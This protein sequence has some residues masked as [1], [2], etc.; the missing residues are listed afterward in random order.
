MANDVQ[1]LGSYLRNNFTK[2]DWIAVAGAIALLLGGIWFV[3]DRTIVAET[4]QIRADIRILEDEVEDTKRDLT[5]Q[6][7]DL[8]TEFGEAE[9]RIVKAFDAFSTDVAASVEGGLTERTDELSRA[10][11]AQFQ[12]DR[13]LTIHVTNVPRD[14]AAAMQLVQGYMADHASESVL[15]PFGN[16]VQWTAQVE[17][18]EGMASRDLQNIL[19]EMRVSHPE[20]ETVMTYEPATWG[21]MFEMIE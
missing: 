21:D 1:P 15:L 20:V 11:I 12:Q 8:R 16:K 4:A 9:S 2:V 7:D 17:D 10:L 3:V 6:F 14:D 5:A 19:E 18:L 13:V